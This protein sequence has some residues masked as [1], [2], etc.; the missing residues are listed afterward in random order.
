MESIIADLKEPI[1][2]YSNK[3]VCKV[4]SSFHKTSVKRCE[5][6]N[7]SWFEAEG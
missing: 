5:E 1:N 6:D 4:G 3:I 2:K 7:S